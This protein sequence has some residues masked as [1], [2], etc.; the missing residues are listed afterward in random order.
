MKKT[1]LF[2]TIFFFTIFLL[3]FL[4]IFYIKKDFG[5][6]PSTLYFNGN[7]VTVDSKE[8]VADAMLVVNGKIESIGAL[9]SIEQANIQNANF[10]NL[11]KRDLKGATVLPGFIDIHTHFALSMF[12]SEM[13]DLSGFK[14]DS[15]KEVWQ[16]FEEVSKNATKD[17]WL[18]FKGL[19]PK[20][21]EEKYQNYKSFFPKICC[22]GFFYFF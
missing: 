8:T 17:S 20:Q 6:T 13:Y 5:K 2:L 16:Y 4:S 11:E 22:N 18:I 15:N 10:K 7:I 21:S 1:I 9:E 14:H 3:V 19:D 12:L